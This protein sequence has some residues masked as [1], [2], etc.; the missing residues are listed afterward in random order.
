MNNIPIFKRGKRMDLEY[1]AKVDA[2]KTKVLKYIMF[3]KRTEKEIREKFKSEDDN[4]F[5]EVIENLKELGYINDN[6]YI[7]R[8]INEFMNLKNMSIKEI[9]YKLLA[10]GINK[11]DIENYIYENGESLLEYEI[12]SAKNIYNKK[13]SSMDFEDIKNYLYKK[14]YRQESIKSIGDEAGE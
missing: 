7:E 14:G 4:I 3:K 1:L 8:S 13:I 10:K 11:N 12:Q 6:S 5:E 2:L 9:E